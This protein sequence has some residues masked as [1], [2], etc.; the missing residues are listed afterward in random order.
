MGD[1]NSPSYPAPSPVLL[2]DTSLAIK[3]I[4]LPNFDGFD[5]VGW[6]TRA[7]RYFALNYT[8][9]DMKI[10]LAL[11]C[12]SGPTLHSLQWLHQRS[13]NLSWLQFSR[14]LLHWYGG[15]IRAN[16]YEQ[17]ATIRQEGSIGNY[18]NV[19]MELAVQVEGMSNQQSLGYF[20]SGLQEEI[21]VQIRS[22]D[23]SDLAYTMTL[24]YGIEMETNFL[25]H[26][27]SFSRRLGENGPR[28][29]SEY[30]L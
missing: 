27:S 20:L 4:E 28:R 30:G 8:R 19:F 23:T 16:H 14:E 17:L 3:K 21:R 13:L 22:H 10:H 1:I 2:K 25:Q 29:S 5:P 7:N 11:V 9:D 15:D 12:I 26:S 24:A 6:L 18:I